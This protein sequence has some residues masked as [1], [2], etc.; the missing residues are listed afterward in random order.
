M[1]LCIQSRLSLNELQDL[2]DEYF[3]DIP[4]NVD[5]NLSLSSFGT[6]THKNAFKTSFYDDM[7]CVSVKTEET[8]LF[9]TWVLPPMLDKYR[10]KPL[11]YV[12]SVLLSD[13]EGS[14]L[15]YLTEK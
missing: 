2:V 7:A 8:R 12:R 15:E 6:Y 9:L 10:T 5:E 14:L 13:S 1:H 3:S 4:H 11:Y